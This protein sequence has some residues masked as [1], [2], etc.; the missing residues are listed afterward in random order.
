MDTQIFKFLNKKKINKQITLGH[1]DIM[2][3]N[4]RIY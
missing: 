1:S 2:F 4:K 3:V